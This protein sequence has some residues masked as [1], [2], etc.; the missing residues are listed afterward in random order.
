MKR[1]LNKK[2]VAIV[3]IIFIAIISMIIFSNKYNNIN[4]YT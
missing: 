2:R 1:R 3:V 4:K